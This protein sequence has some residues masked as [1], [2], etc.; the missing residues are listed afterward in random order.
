MST[1]LSDFL[2]KKKME[3]KK[4]MKLYKKNSTRYIFQRLAW[5]YKLSLLLCVYFMKEG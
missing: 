5:F 4:D 3:D 2:E 1:C